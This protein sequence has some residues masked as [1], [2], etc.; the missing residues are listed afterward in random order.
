MHRCR[1]D[2][3]RAPERGV[4]VGVCYLSAAASTGSDVA[5]L[6]VRIVLTPDVEAGDSSTRWAIGPD[7]ASEILRSWM[8]QMCE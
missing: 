1:V 6:R 4:V 2:P 7:A 3:G 8:A 5:D